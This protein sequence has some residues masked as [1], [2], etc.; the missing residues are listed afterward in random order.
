MKTRGLLRFGLFVLGGALLATSVWVG[1]WSGEAVVGNHWL[2]AVLLAAGFTLGLVL[3]GYLVV[4]LYRDGGGGDPLARPAPP[5]RRRIL[6][7]LGL[8]TVWTIV[9]VV[10]VGLT[11]AIIR[12]EPH[13]A[14]RDG[15][16]AYGTSAV[17]RLQDDEAWFSLVPRGPG[18]NPCPSRTARG[19]AR[20]P[21]SRSRRPVSWST[22]TTRSTPVRTRGPSGRSPRPG[23][24]SSC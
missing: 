14:T 7:S 19:T 23:T 10:S 16:E 6:P 4:L 2:Y 3:L 15:L 21:A 17:I 9:A 1:L 24:S 20:R 5:R 11:A 8:G 12:F 18:E 22:P 13:V